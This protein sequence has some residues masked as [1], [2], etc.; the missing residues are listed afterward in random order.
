MCKCKENHDYDRKCCESCDCEGP[1]GPQGPRGPEGAMGPTGSQGPRG[2]MGPKGD[3]GICTPEQCQGMGSKCESYANVFATV[4]QLVNAYG[5]ADDMVLFDSQNAV[6]ASD[7]DLSMMNVSGEIK[8]LRNA[9]YHMQWQLQARVSPPVPNPT[10]SWSFGFWVNGSLVGGS[11]YSGFTQAPGDDAC[12]ST[13]DIII[14]MKVGDTLK[15]RNTSVSRVSLNPN[16]TGSVFPITI[17]SINI[18]CVKPIP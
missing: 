7:F 5:N 17:A 2:Q 14:E 3:P 10:P 8:F 16:V 12:H 11:I 13:G 4:P 6:S 9:V 15:L 1:I 18:E